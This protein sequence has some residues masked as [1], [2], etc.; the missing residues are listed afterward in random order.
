[1]ATE[2]AVL[3][4]PPRPRAGAFRR[5][6]WLVGAA[7]AVAIFVHAWNDVGASFTALFDGAGSLGNLLHR[8]VPPSTSVF[9]DSV[10]ASIV[11]LDTALLGTAAA[12]VL[13][14]LIAP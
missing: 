4:R 11:T 8:S 5:V 2:A 6:G 7:A 14:L 13:S 10:K 12:L 1:M 9:H 3:R